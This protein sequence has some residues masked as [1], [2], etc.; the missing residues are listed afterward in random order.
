MPRRRFGSNA[1]GWWAMAKARASRLRPARFDELG[2][3]RAFAQRLLPLLVA[4]MAFLAAL[5]LAAML[6]TAGLARHWREG[7]GASLTIQVPAP[8]APAA[9]GG[10]SRADAA[11]AVLRADRS[12]LEARRLSGAELDRLLRPWLGAAPET[13]GLAMPAVI[14][15][16]R[17]AGSPGATEEGLRARLAAAAPGVLVEAAGAWLSRLAALARSLEALAA[18]AL[19]IVGGVAAL[20]VA[21]ATR[22]SLAARREALEIIHGLGA[23]DAY[24]AGRFAGRATWLAAAGGIVGTLAALP[25]L[26]LLARLAA[27]VAALTAPAGQGLMTMAGAVMAASVWLA[28]LPLAAAII[29]W[30]TAQITVRRWLHRL[31]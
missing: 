20:V 31:P 18:L 25:V 15:V 29:G 3:K 4:A 22:A 14:T 23:S 13:L 5:T 24:I 9:S 30:L 1:G 11:L 12:V 7:A 26:A 19:L 17:A 6:A 16:R 27:P 28:S 8:E 2:L 10:G 21:I